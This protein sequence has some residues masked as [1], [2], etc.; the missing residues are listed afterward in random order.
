MDKKEK[1][2]LIKIYKEK[3]TE[4]LYNIVKENINEKKDLELNKEILTTFLSI[5]SFKKY[6]NLMKLLTIKSRKISGLFLHSSEIKNINDDEI[7]NYLYRLFC[8]D[9]TSSYYLLNKNKDNHYFNNNS[10]DFSLILNNCNLGKLSH[11]KYKFM[12]EYKEND[13]KPRKKRKKG[14]IKKNNLLSKLKQ[15]EDNNEIKNQKNFHEFI[16]EEMNSDKKKQNYLSYKIDLTNELK[17]QIEITNNEAGKQRFKTLLE[18]IE[19]L[20]EE[21]IK[22]YFQYLYENY[23]S[24][25]GEIKD[26]IKVREKEERI[27]GFIH[28]LIDDRNT[29]LRRKQAIEKRLHLEDKKFGSSMGEEYL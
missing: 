21:N 12:S 13:K 27:N 25:K 11:K 23:N 9:E 29:I 22:D 4:N 28:N 1:L 15:V 16:Y 8:C 14:T 20:K 7:I 19:S 3:A 17:Y 26:L 24:Y 10:I 18:Q 2:Q 5:K 6:I